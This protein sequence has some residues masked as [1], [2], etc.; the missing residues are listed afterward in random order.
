MKSLYICKTRYKCKEYLSCII[1]N[2]LYV[3]RLTIQN[4]NVP[5]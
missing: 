5:Y 2:V 1:E 4:L 3:N